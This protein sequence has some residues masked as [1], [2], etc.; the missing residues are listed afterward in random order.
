MVSRKLPEGTPGFLQRF[1]PPDNRALQSDDWGPERPDGSRHGSWT[2]ELPGAPASVGGVM[3]LEP[4]A[5]GCAY[6]L[7]GAVSVS[8]PLVGGKAEKFLGDM[9][10]RLLDKEADVLRTMVTR[11]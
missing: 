5:G 3:R 4:T 2:A 7:E 10:G 1:L 8:L 6:V 11:T 9:L